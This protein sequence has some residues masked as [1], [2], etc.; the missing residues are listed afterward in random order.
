MTPDKI[1]AGPG[2]APA[3]DAPK[4]GKGRQGYDRVLSAPVPAVVLALHLQALVT[5]LVGAI[6][7]TSGELRPDEAWYV[8]G[9]LFGAALVYEVVA[10]GLDRRM[11][12]ARSVSVGLLLLHAF[13]FLAVARV[14][15]Q[16]TRAVRAVGQAQAAVS[17]SGPAPRPQ[18]VG[19]TCAGCT[20]RVSA[21]FEAEFCRGCGRPIHLACR[22]E[23]SAGACRSCG[24]PTASKWPGAPSAG[25]RSDTA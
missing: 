15:Y 14:L 17:G 1:P 10:F 4:S 2:K 8:G 6:L 5:V 3:G 9:A 13:A 19:Q 24:L 21:E 20:G 7:V 12:W 22:R 25:P 16:L 23:P 18:L 11:S